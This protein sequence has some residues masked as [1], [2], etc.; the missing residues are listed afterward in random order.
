MNSII[1]FKILPALLSFVFS[2]STSLATPFRTPGQ[3]SAQPRS[4]LCNELRTLAES[5]FNEFKRDFCTIQD[6]HRLN[7]GSNAEAHIPGYR[8]NADAAEALNRIVAFENSMRGMLTQEGRILNGLLQQISPTRRGGARIGGAIG[9]MLGGA[10]ALDPNTLHSISDFIHQV[11]SGHPIAGALAGLAFGGLVQNYRN[12]SRN[13]DALNALKPHIN[14]CF[15]ER[16]KEL[17]LEV[18]HTTAEQRTLDA[19]IA[20]FTQ[21][22]TDR[23]ELAAS[24]LRRQEGIATAQSAFQARADEA[25]RAEEARL[26]AERRRERALNDLVHGIGSCDST[27]AR[28]QAVPTRVR[29]VVPGAAAEVPQNGD[30]VEGQVAPAGPRAATGGGTTDSRAMAPVSR[31]LH[32]RQVIRDGRPVSRGALPNAV[33]A[34]EALSRAPVLVPSPA[35]AGAAASETLAPAAVP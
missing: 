21:W 12:F 20:W 10:T 14:P 7:E 5:T 17:G 13:L 33:R 3:N 16:L 15:F 8:P 24:V 18:P 32:R 30:V 26:D 2:I 34:S 9:M 23:R 22:I 35:T 27:V 25:S 11:G 29:V 1:R 28:V 4:E 31:R 19:N 6:T